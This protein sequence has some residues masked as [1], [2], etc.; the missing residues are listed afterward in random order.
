[1]A[2]TGSQ[3]FPSSFGPAL[4]FAQEE[5]ELAQL[6]KLLGGGAAAAGPLAAFGGPVGLGIGATAG[7]VQGITASKD[8]KRAEKEA[9]K[10]RQ[11]QSVQQTLAQSGANASGLQQLAALLSGLNRP[12]SF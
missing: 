6:A 5:D 10:R 9:K 2:F 4:A 1:M 8:K 12:G 11:Q 7:L 3:Q